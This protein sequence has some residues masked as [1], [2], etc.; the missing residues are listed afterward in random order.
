MIIVFFFCKVFKICGMI[1]IFLIK[2]LVMKN[3]V[4]F[5]LN[6]YIRFFKNEIFG[7]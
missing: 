4:F 5:M 1:K 6:F 3:N 2:L 7:C